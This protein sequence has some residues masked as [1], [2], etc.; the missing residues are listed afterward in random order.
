MRYALL[1][2]LLLSATALRAEDTRMYQRSDGGYDFYDFSGMLVQYSVLNEKGS[3]DFFDRTG[4]SLGWA[5]AKDG[6]KRIEFFDAGGAIYRVIERS[7]DGSLAI[8]SGL[9]KLY[10][11]SAPNALGGNDNYDPKGML[12]SYTSNGEY[13]VVKP[14]DPE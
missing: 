8:S 3:Y 14:N 11:L 7:A 5:E 13:V 12:T 1:F 10:N 9:G 2:I 4:K 6:G